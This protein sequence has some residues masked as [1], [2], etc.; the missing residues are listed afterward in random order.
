MFAGEQI[1]AKRRTFIFNF[2]LMTIITFPATIQKELQQY[3]PASVTPED[4]TITV[5]IKEDIPDEI[6]EKIKQFNVKYLKPEK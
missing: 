5:K 2:Q 4:V 1:C 6:W 3:I